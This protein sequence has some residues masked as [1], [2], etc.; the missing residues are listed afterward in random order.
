[1]DA[2]MNE[3]YS[4]LLAMGVPVYRPYDENMNKFHIS[5]DPTSSR[6][7][8]SQYSYDWPENDGPWADYYQMFQGGYDKEYTFGVHNDIV[9]ALRERGMYAEWNNPEELNVN[10]I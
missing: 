9:E 4:E 6:F 2:S 8:I 5:G 10:Y 7:S 1:M 3:A